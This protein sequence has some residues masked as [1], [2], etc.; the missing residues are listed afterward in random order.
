[1]ILTASS[2]K[3]ECIY[4]NLL[5][6][7]KQPVI[8]CQD[9]RFAIAR[10]HTYGEMCISEIGSSQMVSGAMNEVIQLLVYLHPLQQH[11]LTRFVFM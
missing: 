2:L 10:I 7:M 9:N 8:Q 3:E 1:M 4:R 6:N 5:E 11:N